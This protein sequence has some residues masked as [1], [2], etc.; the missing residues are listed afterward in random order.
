MWQI[1]NPSSLF[2]WEKNKESFLDHTIS[3]YNFSVGR[4]NT[5]KDT[6]LSLGQFLRSATLRQNIMWEDGFRSSIERE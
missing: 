4:F 6:F 2:I 5:P 3:K 1:I